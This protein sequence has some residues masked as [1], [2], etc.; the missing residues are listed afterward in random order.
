MAQ[1]PSPAQERP[2]VLVVEDE[3][4]I[5][6]AIVETLEDAGFRVLIAYNADHAIMLLEAY[7]DIKTVFT[8]VRMPGSMD[9][10]KLAAA[11]RDR[12][13]PVNIIITSGDIR[14]SDSELPE[15]SVFIG[16]PY[17]HSKIVEAVKAF[18]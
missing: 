1:P 11:V 8:D 13:P 6:E 17:L 5:C 7:P 3:P 4:L 16:K 2:L 15:R 18:G 12:W 14:P 10:M 9:G